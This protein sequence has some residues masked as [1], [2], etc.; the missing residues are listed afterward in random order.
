MAEGNVS[1]LS[2]YVN[3]NPSHLL[4]LS[5]LLGMTRTLVALPIQHPWDV[6]KVNWQANSHLK[7]EL[8][9]FRMV[10]A[11]KGLKGFYSGFSTNLTKQL[12]KSFYRYPLISGLP[13][14]Y[15]HLFG[16]RYDTHKHS[17][18][19]LTSLTIALIES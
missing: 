18:K 7:N 19:L 2:R 8:A 10:K 3:H 4:I 12:F 16:S 14:F 6:M 11:D 15:S 5:S 13:R 17:M 1:K 9:V